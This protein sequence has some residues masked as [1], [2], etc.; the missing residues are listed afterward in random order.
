M[1]LE[2]AQSLINAAI[3]EAKR[4]EV[5]I[6]VTVV[7]SG[8]HLVAFARMDGVSYITIDI[9]RR[10]ALTACNYRVPSQKVFMLS[11]SHPAMT[12]EFT[13]NDE[14]C[15]V[16]GGLPLELA[17]VCIGG[18]GISGAKSPEQ[19]EKIALKAKSILTNF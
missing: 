5:N 18:L 2:I 1:N 16:G 13:K 17:D 9:T 10:K 4:L 14:L 15:M 12:V 8:G 6:A 11:L 3:D 19:D 7:D